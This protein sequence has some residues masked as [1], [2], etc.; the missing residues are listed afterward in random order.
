M[1]I[2]VNDKPFDL[3]S[4]EELNP[5][6][7]YDT[8]YH[9]QEDLPAH[10]PWNDDILFHEPSHDLIIRLLYTLRTR[11]LKDLDSIT[12]VTKDKAA[13]KKFVKSRFSIIKA[14]GGVVSKKDKMLLI[15]RLGKWD[16]PKGKFEKGETPKQCAVRE[17][18]EE[19]A[20]KVKAGKK[21]CN[22]W[23]TYT[24]DRKSILKKTYWFEMDCLNDS[25]MTPQK[26][27][28]IDDI[29]WFYEGDAKIA[30]INSYPSMRFL[31]KQYI[32]THLKP[33][34]L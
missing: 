9:Q 28:G 22:T 27:E 11:K 1:R 17:V 21:I 14:A 16:F 13:L 23:H 19:C 5:A 24:Q 20:V 15:F 12:L 29:R 4:Y 34:I 26:E 6:K 7:S 30:L 32:K 31:F 10:L 3:I 18:E 8:V 33:Q 25:Q 2:F